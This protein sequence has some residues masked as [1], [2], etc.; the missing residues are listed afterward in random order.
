MEL[1]NIIESIIFVS[2]QPVK[3]TAILDIL[4]QATNEKAEEA[5]EENEEEKAEKAVLHSLETIQPLLEELLSKYSDDRYPFEIRKVANGFQFFTKKAYYP[6]V[7]NATLLRH[8]KRLTRAALETLAIIAYRQPVTKAEL[9][10]IRGVNCDYGVQKLLEKNLVSIL[11]RADAVGKPLLYGTSEFFMQYFGINGVED[12]PKLQEFEEL[13]EDHLD[14]FKQHQENAANKA[15]KTDEEIEEDE[16]QDKDPNIEVE[17]IL[18][19]EIE[20]ETETEE[21]DEEEK[22]D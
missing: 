11:G 19:Q 7:K 13:M 12:L 9:E 3:I 21:E 4:N 17:N 16:I 8:Q 10:F 15:A 1:L 20:A 14:L 18:E 6:Y 5:P 2:D 22:E